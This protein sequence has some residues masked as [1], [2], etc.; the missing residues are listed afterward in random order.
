MFSDNEGMQKGKSKMPV[1]ID[2]IFLKCLSDITE[3]VKL[4]MLWIHLRS[5]KNF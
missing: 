1:F 5:N 2:E 3:V 4:L